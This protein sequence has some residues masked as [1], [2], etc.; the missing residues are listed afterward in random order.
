MKKLL[1]VSTL[2]VVVAFASSAC[3]QVKE[4]GFGQKG[5]IAIQVLTAAPMLASDVIGYELGATPILG[6]NTTTHSGPERTVAGTTTQ[7]STRATA[8]YINPRAHYFLIDHLSLGG[9]VL[10]ATISAKDIVKTNGVTT[11]TTRDA[12][13]ALGLMPLIGYDIALSDKFSIWPQGGI[14]FR[15]AW[16]THH[17]DRGAD[18][19]FGESWWFF[20]ADVPFMFHPLPH[21]SLGVGP[22]V[23]VTLSKSQSATQGG[24][25]VSEDHSTT[26]I[27]WLS[28][29]LVGWF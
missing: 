26:Q 12:P 25:T 16:Y 24:T 21:F 28:A 23:T 29:T 10:F 11:E 15:R 1:S 3:A 14:G 7:S 22:G 2:G 8:F 5:T 27:R 20:A 19:D 9:E 13:N 18:T 4:G 6:L 17:P